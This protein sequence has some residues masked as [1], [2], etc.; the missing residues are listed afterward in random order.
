MAAE[1]ITGIVVD[2][3]PNLGYK[4]IVVRVT[5]TE[6][7]DW[8][9]VADHVT[10]VYYASGFDVTS[11]AAEAITVTDSTKLVMAAGGTSDVTIVAMGV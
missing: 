5:C 9:D 11:G 4:Q 7:G 10:T 2:A 6:N 8:V 3:I 1:E